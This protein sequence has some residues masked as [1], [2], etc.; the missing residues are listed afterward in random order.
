MTIREYAKDV[1]IGV[2]ISA[3]I[4]PIGGGGV[5]RTTSIASKGRMEGIK[6]GARRTAVVAVFG[7]FIET[8]RL[9]MG[10]FFYEFIVI[11]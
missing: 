4:G 1:A 7:I 5:S 3:I 6:Q 8:L 11:R 10:L 2:T 9:H